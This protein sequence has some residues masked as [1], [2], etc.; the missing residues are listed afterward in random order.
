[1]RETI[2]I[3]FRFS[4]VSIVVGQFSPLA[5]S[6]VFE[7]IVVM[8]EASRKLEV[9]KKALLSC[10]PA[11]EVAKRPAAAKLPPQA[12]IGVAQKLPAVNKPT[13]KPRKK[14]IATTMASESSEHE[15][16]LVEERA[17]PAYMRTNPVGRIHGFDYDRELQNRLKADQARNVLINIPRGTIGNPA[18]AHVKPHRPVS[19]NC[20]RKGDC[21]I[22]RCACFRTGAVCNSNCLC[23]QSNRKCENSNCPEFLEMRHLSMLKALQTPFTRGH[24]E[25]VAA[26][27]QSSS[28]QQ[29]QKSGPSQQKPMQNTTAI[30][31]R[32]RNFVGQYPPVLDLDEDPLRYLEPGDLVAGVPPI[33]G[34]AFFVGNGPQH[35]EDVSL[36]LQTKRKR[37]DV[38]MNVAKVKSLEYLK[39]SFADLRQK[40]EE[41]M[42]ADS[43][44]VASNDVLPSLTT[45]MKHLSE[46][47]QTAKLDAM[48]ELRPVGGLFWRKTSS[49]RASK[50][51]KDD[52]DVEIMED[53]CELLC[54]E[55]AGPKKRARVFNE[56]EM[57]EKT[58]RV[59]QQTALLRAATQLIRE[60]TRRFAQQRHLREKKQ[61]VRMEHIKKHVSQ[62]SKMVDASH[63]DKDV[64]IIEPDEAKKTTRNNGKRS[65]KKRA[66]G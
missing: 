1:M 25:G 5:I 62:R 45:D 42:K 35:S 52:M 30:E 20:K 48:T 28:T 27:S 41:G 10:G 18:D 49:K 13:V 6:C 7:L 56:D 63:S 54:D 57:Q 19:C 17:L 15:Q 65:S 46:A 37:K 12:A 8:S 32:L 23:C 59:Y 47:M 64:V 11:S 43:D 51:E 22:L 29:D 38:S 14:T 33:N 2:T 26:S 4:T 16:P 34:L 50:D 61:S 66:S 36:L 40:Q 24:A 21:S 55:D 31:L 60:Q 44:K 53:D 39:E 9:A 3:T 58:V